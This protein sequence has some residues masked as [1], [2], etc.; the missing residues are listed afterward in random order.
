VDEPQRMHRALRPR[1]RTRTPSRRR[2]T[3]D[4]LPDAEQAGLPTASE[5]T[6]ALTGPV[7]VDGR[8]VTRSSTSM[9]SSPI[10]RAARDYPGPRG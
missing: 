10:A 4:S 6:A 1:R 9:T 8:R 5:R 7:E 3:Y 2:H